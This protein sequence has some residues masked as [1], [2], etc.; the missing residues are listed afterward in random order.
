MAISPQAV[1]HSL[2]YYILTL[3]NMLQ[4]KVTHT[5]KRI[6]VRTYKNK[7]IIYIVREDKQAKHYSSIVNAMQILIFYTLAVCVYENEDCTD[8][9]AIGA[10]FIGQTRDSGS[11][12]RG[13]G[14]TEI[15]AVTTHCFNATHY[16][17]IYWQ[18]SVTSPNK[19]RVE[20]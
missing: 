9:N 5:F 6:G 2:H 16:N 8:F 1:N 17:Y 12:Y 18:W 20:H 13:V 10:S 11:S 15:Q 4:L 14:D 19:R 3:S 7:M